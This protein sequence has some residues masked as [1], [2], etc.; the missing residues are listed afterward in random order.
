MA[1]VVSS[2]AQAQEQWADE[3]A[4]AA[5]PSLRPPPPLGLT[6]GLQL[7]VPFGPNASP[8]PGV[9]LGLRL[10]LAQHLALTVLTTAEF[11]TYV[12]WTRPLTGVGEFAKTSELVGYGLLRLEVFTASAF[13]NLLVPELSF[14]FYGGA[15][16]GFTLNRATATLQAGVHL[17]ITRLRPSGWW[18]PVFIDV[19]LD[20]WES[21]P[22]LLDDGRW[23]FAVGVGL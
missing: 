5:P 10:R 17:G 8:T 14:G 1:L 11:A 16:A 12:D 22:R 13:E 9:R 15:G 19:G 2:W 21:P 23:R 18:C 3:P 7:S 20:W 4:P 6:A